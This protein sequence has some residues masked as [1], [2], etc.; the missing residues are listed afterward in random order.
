ML[1]SLLVL[2]CLF[3]SMT[4]CAQSADER[5]GKL[6]EES[7]W[8]DLEHELKTTPAGEVTPCLRKMALAMTHHCFNRPDSACIV[9]SDLLANHQNELGGSLL[10]MV[11]LL[12]TSQARTGDYAGAAG[13]TGEV[14]R[15]LAAL[16][17]DASQIAPYAALVRQYRALA[18]FGPLCRPLHKAG[19]YRF[20][21]ILEGE[22]DQHFIKLDG[23]INGQSCRMIFDTGAGGNLISPQLAA[24]FGLRMSEADVTVGGI[25][26]M[27]EGRYAVADTL[28]IGGMVWTDVPFFV[29]DTRS[30]HAEADRIGKSGQLPP[31]VGLPLMF[32][33]GEI[34][35]DFDRREVVVPARPTRNPLDGSNLI[36]TDTESL[37]LKAADGAGNPLWFHFDTGSYYTYMQPS[38]YARHREQVEAVGRAD[39]LRMG[40]IGGVSVTRSY[41][42]PRMTF[43]I[44]NGTAALDS[45]SVNTGADLHT[46]QNQIP[47][48]AG[49]REDGVA[50]LNLLEKFGRVII[51]LKDMYMEAFPSEGRD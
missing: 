7:R 8:F 16:G 18:S 15:Q 21:M 44:G 49:G 43:R 19:E 29:V 12:G 42:L 14:C 11:M 51:N 48:S 6:I 47:S 4:A 32:R 13:L 50:G 38:W 2:S 37:C 5:I 46:G 1:K 9:L 36:R 3:F 10:N 24:R 23:S 26:G 35:L 17:M 40:G 41:V 27:K 31:V 30:G 28:R 22:G 34:C 20:P 39:T 25:G 33:M 45:V